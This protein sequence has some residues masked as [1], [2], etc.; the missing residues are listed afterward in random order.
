MVTVAISSRALT[1]VVA[2]VLIRVVANVVSPFK[3]HT[4]WDPWSNP[5]PR[6][7]I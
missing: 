7:R 1:N 5:E 4:A 6:T 3:A 2:L